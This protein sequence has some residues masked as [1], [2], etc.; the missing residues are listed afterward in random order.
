MISPCNSDEIIPDLLPVRRLHNYVYCPRLFYLQWVE[1]IFLPNEDTVIGSSIHKRV[2][3]PERLKQ[4]ILTEN[5]G[6]LRSLHLSS[7]HLG[8]TGIIDLLEHDE[9]ET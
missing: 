8:I 9:C 3:E 7:E 5:G 6:N 1:D 4:D 2:D